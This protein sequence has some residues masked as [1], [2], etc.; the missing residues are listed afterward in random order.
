[1]AYTSGITTG[2]QTRGIDLANASDQVKL[3]IRT[4]LHVRQEVEMFHHTCYNE[5]CRIARKI[6]VDI[7]R[8][9]ICGRQ[10]HRQNA[11]QLDSGL[12][13]EQLTEDYFRINV[14]VPMLDDVLGSL[15]TR[16]EEGQENV[17]KGTM[18]LPSST[19]SESDWDSAVDTFI[20]AYIDEIPSI[21]TLEAEKLLWKQLWQEK[22]KEK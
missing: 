16:F 19:I 3:V 12:S 9:R 1:M 7:K 4:L 2:L 14:T 21:C 15:Q 11:L 13:D 17:M 10:V 18:L 5:S 22:W 6:N 20:Q 8:P